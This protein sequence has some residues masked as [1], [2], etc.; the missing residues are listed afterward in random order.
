[1]ILI[2]ITL[3]IWL[4]CLQLGNKAG[5]CR[6]SPES[7]NQ[8]AIGLIIGLTRCIKCTVVPIQQHNK[9]M[10]LYTMKIT[11]GD[12]LVDHLDQISSEEP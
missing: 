10:H 12:R 7:L 1:M 3:I 8:A 11:I 9:L 6:R 5:G 2:F 4:N